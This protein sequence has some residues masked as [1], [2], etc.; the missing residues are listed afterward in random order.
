MC[1]ALNYLPHG[2]RFHYQLPAN[3]Q[4]LVPIA[5]LLLGKIDALCGD[6]QRILPRGFAL[7]THLGLSTDWAPKLLF[8]GHQ[9]RASVQMKEANLRHRWCPAESFSTGKLF[10]RTI[11]E[12]VEELLWHAIGMSCLPPAGP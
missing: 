11:E 3:L 12:L 8:M 6:P 10:D 1:L 5:I 4:L 7:R 2:L 9:G